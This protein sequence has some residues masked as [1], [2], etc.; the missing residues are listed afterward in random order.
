MGQ[1]DKEVGEGKLRPHFDHDELL[2]RL[3]CV[4][5]LHS[6]KTRWRINLGKKYL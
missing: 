1:G 4:I 5:L 2:P 6:T 3:S